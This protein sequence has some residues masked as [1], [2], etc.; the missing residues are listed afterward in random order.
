MMSLP[1]YT[2]ILLAETASLSRI[3]GVEVTI[4]ATSQALMDEVS[5]Q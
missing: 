2:C 1:I 3:P 5:R 4:L